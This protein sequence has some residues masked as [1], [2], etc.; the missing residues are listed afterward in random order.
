KFATGGSIA[1][2]L[3]GG[4][5]GTDALSYSGNTGSVT[6]NLQAHTATGIGGT[7][8]DVAVLV[9]DPTTTLVGPNAGPTWAVTGANAGTAAGLS[10]SAVQNL[11]GGTGADTFSFGASGSVSGVVDGGGGAN[12]LDFHQRTTN[13]TV[14]LQATGPNKATATGGFVN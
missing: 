7:F 9:G 11:T 6:V 8:A 2:N 10:F 12:T 1:G 14:T 13:V 4:P 5:G 3:D